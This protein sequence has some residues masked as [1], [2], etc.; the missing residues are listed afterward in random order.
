MKLAFALSCLSLGICLEL[1]GR[2]RLGGSG[3]VISILG[4]IVHN[5]KDVQ[6]VARGSKRM[7][8]IKLMLQ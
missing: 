5:F 1:T 8:R 6:R 4:K 2:E 7:L 3:A